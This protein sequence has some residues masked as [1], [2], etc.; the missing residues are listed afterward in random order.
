MRTK[1]IAA[2]LGGAVLFL[3]VQAGPSWAATSGPQTWTV[4]SRNGQPTRVVASGVVNSAGTVKDYLTLHLASGTFD[5][6]AVQTFPEGTLDYHGQGTAVLSVDPVTCVG[7]GRF[8]GPFVITG[9]TGAY[10]GATGS[11]TA[12]GDLTFIFAR[13]PT[14][15]SQTPVQSWGVAHA[16][17]ELTIP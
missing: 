15:C 6:F 17:G 12:I 10:A 3:L 14:G 13:T 7:K 2:L 16:T 11:G 5:N 9:G 8:V 1:K 4:V